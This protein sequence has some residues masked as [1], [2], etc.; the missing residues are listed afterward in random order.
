MPGIT[1]PIVSTVQ[2]DLRQQTPAKILAQQDMS[3]KVRETAIPEVTATKEDQEALIEHEAQRTDVIDNA[4][5]VLF[6]PNED[7]KTLAQELSLPG[8]RDQ[9]SARARRRAQA[10]GALLRARGGLPGRRDEARSHRAAGG[11]LP[12]DRAGP[13]GRLL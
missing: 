13:A 10:Q 2:T 8:A 3:T 9:L 4:L 7:H 12:G 1:L 11:R 5:T 6:E